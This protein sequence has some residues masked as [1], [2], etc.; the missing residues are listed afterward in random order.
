M[1]DWLLDHTRVSLRVLFGLKALLAAAV[2]VLSLATADVSPRWVLAAAFLA[3]AALNLYETV[4]LSTAWPVA[5]ALV[6]S[7]GASLF[8]VLAL[9]VAYQQGEA[10]LD[11]PHFAMSVT[12]WLGLAG[13]SVISTLGGASHLGTRRACRGD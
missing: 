13:F 4:T 8:R 7:V 1:A 6:L 9:C 12:L 3:A 2:G 10:R 5:A 11:G